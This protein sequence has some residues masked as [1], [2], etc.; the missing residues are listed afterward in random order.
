MRKFYIE[1][2]WSVGNLHIRI[3]GEF[4]GMCAWELVKVIKRQPLGSGRIFV[5]TAGLNRI[6]P[7]AVDLFKSLMAHWKLPADWLYFKGSKGFEIAPDGCRV[8]VCSN[9]QPPQKKPLE[10][11]GGTIRSTQY[12]K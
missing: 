9:A 12:R 7:A 2:R 3:A 6:E 1:N 8:L 5:S 10:N 4:S 11:R